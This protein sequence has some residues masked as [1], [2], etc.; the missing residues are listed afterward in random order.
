MSKLVFSKAE[1]RF[2]MLHTSQYNRPYNQHGLLLYELK[3]SA[4]EL[5]QSKYISNSLY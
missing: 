3:Q 5:E 4:S 2:K 1:T